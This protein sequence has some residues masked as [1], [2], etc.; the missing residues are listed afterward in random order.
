MVVPV[1]EVMTKGPARVTFC[2]AVMFTALLTVSCVGGVPLPMTPLNSM[3]PAVPAV[4]DKTCAPS[5]VLLIVLKL[6]LAPVE[7]PVAVSIVASSFKI[8]ASVI[9]TAPPTVLRI[10]PKVAWLIVTAAPLTV[11]ET[12]PTILVRLAVLVKPLLS[13]TPFNV[14][15]PVFKK[16]A[17]LVMLPPLFNNKL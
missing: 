14:T 5:I 11:V 12:V 8:N 7:P 3:L 4:R 10:L 17:A 16:V 2:T 9:V 6:I 13:V 1:D 15:P